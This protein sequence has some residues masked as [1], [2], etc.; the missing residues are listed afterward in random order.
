[1]IVYTEDRKGV[2]SEKSTFSDRFVG[3]SGVLVSVDFGERAY[4]WDFRK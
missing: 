1:M 2:V 4:L 3:V